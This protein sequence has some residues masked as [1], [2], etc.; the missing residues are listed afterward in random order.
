MKWHRLLDIPEQKL[1]LDDSEW[2]IRHM[3]YQPG[4]IGRTSIRTTLFGHNAKPLTFKTKT[5]WHEL[6]QNGSRW[7]SDLPI[8]Q[9]QARAHLPKMRGHVLV[10]GLGLGMFVTMLGYQR[11]VT[12]V[13]V[14]EL[15]RGVLQLVEPHTRMHLGQPVEY[16]QGDLADYIRAADAKAFDAAFFDIWTT[17]S[18]GQFHDETLP[19][20]KA[21]YR[22]VTG[23]V[24]CW[25][26]DVMRGQLFQGIVTRLL[27]LSGKLPAAGLPTLD[28][29]CNQI[30]S[31][32]HDWSVPFWCWLR[33][34]QALAGSPWLD[35]DMTRRA[36]AYYVQ[37]FERHDAAE[38][39]HPLKSWRHLRAGGHSGTGVA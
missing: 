25:N 19:L 14:V 2:A 4:D 9:F 31:K 8:E 29:L 37:T 16:V 13:T 36:A 30:G 21:G 11:R 18:E 23:A 7:M 10:G 28:E 32:Y 33:Q 26:E 39:W 22:I 1:L 5:R 15:S 3:I 34:E 17:D 20:K 24:E 27:L 12:R 35:D 6:L 38:P